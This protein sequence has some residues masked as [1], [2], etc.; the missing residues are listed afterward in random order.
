MSRQP[1]VATIFV[2]GSVHIYRAS[3]A[4]VGRGCSSKY[5]YLDISARS[6][7]FARSV[8]AFLSLISIGTL[9]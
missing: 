3:N 7:Q 4:D 2:T 8:L 9:S 1:D 5:E 6:V